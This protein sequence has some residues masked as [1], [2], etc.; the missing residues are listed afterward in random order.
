MSA[1]YFHLPEK[2]MNT[3]TLR[4]IG[5]VSPGVDRRLELLSALRL[6]Y[7]PDVGSKIRRVLHILPH[8]HQDAIVRYYAIPFFLVSQDAEVPEKP[9]SL[10]TIARTLNAKP[11]TVRRWIQF[12]VARMATYLSLSPVE[13]HLYDLFKGDLAYV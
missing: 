5:E 4:F 9:E 13:R 10:A 7:D 2:A 11:Q 1:P 12:G 6:V 8:K 3:V